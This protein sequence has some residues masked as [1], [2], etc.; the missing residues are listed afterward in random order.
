MLAMSSKEISAYA[1]DG[2][3][4]RKNLLSSR[5]IAL[6]RDRARAPIEAEIKAGSV[7]AKKDEEGRTGLVKPLAKADENQY[8]FLGRDE[9]LV[10]LAQ[11]AIGKPVYRY[12]HEISLKQPIVGGAWDWH[13]DFGFF[14][15]DGLLAPQMATIFV[16]L[17]TATRENGC[18]RVLKGSHK[19]GRLNHNTDLIND[20]ANV[21]RVKQTHVEREQLA[22]AINLFETVYVE[23][24]PGD[25]MIFDCN[26]VH[27]SGANRSNTHLW[28]YICY[29]NAVENGHYKEHEYGHYEPLEKISATT[30][31]TSP[32]G[33]A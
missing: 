10:D 8:G 32:N 12:A 15:A 30:F 3:I 28:A 31:L 33:V 19:L 14:H 1:V 22:A 18:L 17:E 29:Y 4:V 26:L 9:R 27:G 16:P 25:V 6:Y 24:D 5:E 13:Q 20:R 11:V 23:M 21:I 7:L 2:Y